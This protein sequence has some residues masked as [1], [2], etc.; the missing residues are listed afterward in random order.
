MKTFFKIFLISTLFLTVS[1][2]KEDDGMIYVPPIQGAELKPEVGGPNQPNQVW[3]DLSTGNMKMTNR[4]SWDLGFY[5]G[6]QFAVILNTSALMSASPVDG[7][8]DLAEINSTNMAGL[9]SVVQVANFDPNN[10][11]YIDDVRGN[12]LN[13]GTVIQEEN[14]IYLI[15]MGYNIP[16]GPFQP[17]T[18]YAA[19]TARGWKKIKISSEGNGY[20][21]EYADLNSTQTNEIYLDKD[22]NYN[23]R[24]FS[25]VTEQVMDIQPPK[26]DWDICF[27]VFVNHVFDNNGNDNGSYIYTDFVMSNTMANTGAYEVITTESTLLSDF[28][29]FSG[30]DVDESLFI[31]DDHRAIGS[32][33][34][35]VPGA[36]LKKDRFY[37]VKDPN[38][39]LF[40]LRFIA[41]S[42]PDDSDPNLFW[43]GYPVFEYDPL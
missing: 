8:T 27:T 40:K 14:K 31:Y 32:N 17:G 22:E 9:M 30:S 7:Y 4:T 3:V 39:V 18:S 25:L 34:R 37:V 43:R 21:L 15:N 11:N 5:T 26:K 28:N 35:I 20:R 29:D 36:I 10:I 12:Y 42:K 19:G 6:D 41:M 23:F 1:C 33:W 38:G 16:D 13:D 2:L 24:F